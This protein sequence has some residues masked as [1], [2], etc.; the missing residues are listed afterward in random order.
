MVHTDANTDP[1]VNPTQVPDLSSDVGDV[2]PSQVPDLSSDTGAV[3][4]PIALKRAKWLEYKKRYDEKHKEAIMEYRKKYNKYKYSIDREQLIERQKEYYRRNR[5]I[6]IQ[7]CK[8]NYKI[9]RELRIKQTLERIRR[10]KEQGL[11]D[12][13]E[14]NEPK[15][16]KKKKSENE[17][18]ETKRANGRKYYQNRKAR[19]E[20]MKRKLAEYEAKEKGITLDDASTTASSNGGSDGEH[21]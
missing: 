21:P 12:P 4:D 11:M 2:D 3:L 18:I 9:N 16:A 13:K 5:E 20:E 6:C 7:R 1:V 14:P 8:D 17:D 10:K 15:E 19:L